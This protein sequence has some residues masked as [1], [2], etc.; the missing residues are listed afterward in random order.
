MKLRKN[1]EIIQNIL[2]NTA[3]PINQVKLKNIVRISPQYF[4]YYTM[5]LF[6]T[7]KI[8]IKGEKT[9]ILYWRTNKGKKMLESL[10]KFHRT[11]NLILRALG[12]TKKDRIQEKEKE[13]I[14]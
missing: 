12:L 1:T 4:K 8:A 2:A 11:Q 5:K 10:K 13:M 6:Q 3:K 9:Q 14:L 7:G